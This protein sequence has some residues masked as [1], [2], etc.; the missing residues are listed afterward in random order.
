MG[1][2]ARTALAVA[3]MALAGN[4][5]ARA[6][7][8]P[9]DKSSYF[10]FEPRKGARFDFAFAFQD[11]KDNYRLTFGRGEL[12]LDRVLGGTP[13]TLAAT[14]ELP[15]F[16]TVGVWMRPWE[17]RV[18]LDGR[19]ALLSDDLTFRTGRSELQPPDTGK[20]QEATPDAAF[21]EDF[22]NHS[23]V[24][25]RWAPILGS[26]SIVAPKDDLAGRQGN[27]P[28]YSVY[29]PDGPDLNLAVAGD[30]HWA[31]VRLRAVVRIEKAN[32]AGIAFNLYDKANFSA[33][34]L[35]PGTEGTG[36]AHL[37]DCRAGE[38]VKI[39]TFNNLPIARNQW[40]ELAV[41][42][43]ANQ[44]WC[45]LDGQ[46]L[47]PSY[48]NSPTT[49]TGR[50]G[51]VS[52]G[53]GALFDDVTARSAAG[54]IDQFD[55]P[56]PQVWKI[57]GEMAPR[58]SA[59]AGTGRARL[60][61]WLKGPSRVDVELAED[62]A[63]DG[64]MEG[65][66]FT[67]SPTEG[68]FYA[69]GLF[70]G[71]WQFRRV[72]N[73]QLETL[74]KAPAAKAQRYH[75][76]LI[77][78]GGYFRCLVDDRDVFEVS[79]FSLPVFD[80]GLMGRRAAFSN[81]RLAEAGEQARVEVFAIEFGSLRAAD[82][83]RRR[84]GF[85]LGEILQP[86]RPVWGYRMHGAGALLT[87]DE[88]GALLF[89]EPITGDVS[90]AA[91]V[92]AAGGPAVG[93]ALDDKGLGGYKFGLD[94]AGA[95]LVLSR[96]NAVIAQRPVGGKPEAMTIELVRRGTTLLAYA[97]SKPMLRFTDPA[98]LGGTRVGFA[99]LKGAAFYRVSITCEGAAEYSFKHFAP[100]W[101]ESSGKWILHAGLPDATLDHWITGIADAKPAC[102]WERQERQGDLAWLVTVAPATEGYADGGSKK[103][104][105]RNVS[106]RFFSQNEDPQSG[107]TLLLR[108][109]DKPAAALLKNGR[110]VAEKKDLLLP[111]DQPVRVE[112]S[113]LGAEIRVSLNGQQALQF[114]D[115]T[116]TRKGCLGLGV[117]GGR[118]DF[119]DVLVLPIN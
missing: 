28:M 23:R 60:V 3:L 87:C 84:E 57:T 48:H 46:A 11:P 47:Y 102:L 30:A 36:K 116:P 56:R 14:K 74:A 88:P 44:A 109:D 105:L 77:D 111:A 43:C 79:D 118:A 106:L 54:F 49:G 67:H 50:I 80:G 41:E 82:K 96:E 93:I 34:L 103:F 90:V 89:R 24:A 94:A 114:N 83:I 58:D 86:V 92:G 52:L 18:E 9:A 91:S 119:L 16:T 95:N 7:G 59:L 20:V 110:K 42:T 35:E 26:W 8:E 2:S 62:A 33:L 22:E 71:Q 39:L 19:T 29:R 40:H 75:L 72:I 13:V 104:P 32:Q 65:A 113:R 17:I 6:A 69:F 76:T 81:F 112:M 115:G 107:Y 25:E 10:S 51:L 53:G 73:S 108:P 21:E 70:A 97:D 37:V 1:S 5:L 61:K 101:K 64:G 66:I 45:S 100:E 38:L 99:G 63:P 78:H 31:D 117:E 27:R 15:E 12:R 85:V 55:A 98:P 68:S 4:L